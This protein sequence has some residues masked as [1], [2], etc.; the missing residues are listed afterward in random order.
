MNGLNKQVLKIGKKFKPQESATLIPSEIL[1]L[2]LNITFQSKVYFDKPTN[3][4]SAEV[5]GLL[6]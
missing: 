1:D 4:Y 6:G 5:E 2:I 3:Q